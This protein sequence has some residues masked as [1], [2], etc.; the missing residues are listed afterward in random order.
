MLLVS[1]SASVTVLFMRALA[2]FGWRHLAAYLPTAH[3]TTAALMLG[4]DLFASAATAASPEM[5][6]EGTPY[7]PARAA[8]MPN[9]PVSR[10]LMKRASTALPE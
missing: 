8:F 3:L 7:Q 6:T 4:T 5:K 1:A 10:P 9:S 2:F